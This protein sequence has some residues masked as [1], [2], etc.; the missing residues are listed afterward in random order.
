MSQA[1]QETE[2]RNEREQELE[3]AI[4]NKQD[5]IEALERKVDSQARL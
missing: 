3:L 4:R 1:D 2:H 5:A